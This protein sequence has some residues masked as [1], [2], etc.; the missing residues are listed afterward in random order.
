MPKLIGEA[1]PEDWIVDSLIEKLIELLGFLMRR[2]G[3][4]INNLS[5]TRVRELGHAKYRFT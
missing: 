3:G 5:S 4:G 1:L 2:G